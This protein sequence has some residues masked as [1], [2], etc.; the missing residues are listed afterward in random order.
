MDTEGG[1]KVSSILDDASCKIARFNAVGLHYNIV[2]TKVYEERVTVKNPFDRSFVQYIIAGLIA[3]DMQRTMGE[4]KLVYRYEEGCFAL[5]LETALREVRR[6]LEPLL[7]SDIVKVD[8]SAQESVIRG[9]YERLASNGS[10]SLDNQSRRFEV[11]ATKVLHFLNPN[12]FVIVDSNASRA[13]PL[14][15]KIHSLPQGHG[16]PPAGWYVD[17]LRCAQLDI[18]NY[19]VD[20]FQALEPRTPLTRIYDKLTF[21]T[22]REMSEKHE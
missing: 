16:L 1:K 6:P 10:L 12:L 2:A 17:C 21:I 3:F 15:R 22:G 14:A 13:M 19:G 11:G 20:R 8:L 4:S 18:A 7:E 5:R 9:I